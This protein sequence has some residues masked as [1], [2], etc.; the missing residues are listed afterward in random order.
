MPGLVSNPSH[1]CASRFPGATWDAP[2]AFTWSE[3][4]PGSPVSGG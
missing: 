1:D 3:G 4:R 2:D